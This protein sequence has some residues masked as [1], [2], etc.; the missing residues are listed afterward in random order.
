MIMIIFTITTIIRN[1]DNTIH[2]N[3]KFLID[4]SLFNIFQDYFIKYYNVFAV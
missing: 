1:A 2:I 4:S 3:A